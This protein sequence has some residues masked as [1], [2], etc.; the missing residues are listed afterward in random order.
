MAPAVALLTVFV[1]VPVGY[2]VYIAFTN[3]RL[4]GREALH[5]E[6]VGLDNFRR[7]IDSGDL[8]NSARLTLIF[9]VGSALIGSSI[10][11]STI[12]A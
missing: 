7:L 10:G 9:V 11:S 8:A 5:P 12:G 1:L 3:T 4:T 2:A 6:W